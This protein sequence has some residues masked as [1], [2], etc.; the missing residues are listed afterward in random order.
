[1]VEIFQYM[2]S[3]G[4][5]SGF[6]PPPTLFPPTDPAEFSTP[7]SINILVMYDIY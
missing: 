3:L 1:M 5:A 6:A 7:I 2:Q 4:V